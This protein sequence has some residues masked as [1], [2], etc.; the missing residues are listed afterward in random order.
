MVGNKAL[1]FVNGDRL[2]HAA[3]GAFRFALLVA[4]TAADRR[5]RVLGADQVQR[6]L[7]ASLRSKLQVTLHRDMC[8]ARHLARRRAAWQDVLAVLAVVRVPCFFGNNVVGELDVLLRL[9]VDRGAELLAE[10]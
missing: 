5:Q 4:D 7:I 2:V 10:F 6:I 8:G 1:D 3:A 9:N